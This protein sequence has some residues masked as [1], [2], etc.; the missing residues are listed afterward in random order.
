MVSRETAAPLCGRS[1]SPGPQRDQGT[2]SGE[3]GSQEEVKSCRRHFDCGR[4]LA[5][6]LWHFAC[7]TGGQRGVSVT[8]HSESFGLLGSDELLF[9]VY[10]LNIGQMPLVLLHR[11]FS[12]FLP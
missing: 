8:T 2:W 7:I 12:A 11:H 10:K 5:A 3:D 4:L 6:V 1:R 9:V